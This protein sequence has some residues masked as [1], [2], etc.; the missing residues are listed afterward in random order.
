MTVWYCAKKPYHSTH[1]V[2][3][4]RF[5]SVASADQNFRDEEWDALYYYRLLIHNTSSSSREKNVPKK[6]AKVWT[7]KSRKSAKQKKK[8]EEVDNHLIIIIIISTNN[9]HVHIT[10]YTYIC[11]YCIPIWHLFSFKL[12]L[13]MSER[14]MVAFPHHRRHHQKR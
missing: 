2:L 12:Y 6:M 11:T 10:Y 3:K 9:L 4:I 1:T 13:T 7:T 14:S 8:P 5:T